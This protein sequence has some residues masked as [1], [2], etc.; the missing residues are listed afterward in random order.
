MNAIFCTIFICSTII[1]CIVNPNAFLSTLLGGVQTAATTALTLFCVYVVWMGISQ[2]CEDSGINRG[3]AKIL[4]PLCRKL[5]K[6]HDIKAINDISM[7]I[8]CNLLGIGGAA[9]PY[10]V[11][12][13]QQLEKEDNTF[14]QNML[15]II[16]AT[17]IQILPTTVITLRAAAASANPNDI[18]LPSLIATSISTLLGICLYI[19]AEKIR[20]HFNRVRSSKKCR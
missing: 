10:A 14:A 3:A 15:F 18:F 11:K 17:S 2:V 20:E 12:A 1:I 19:A 16:N 4:Q 8:S 13:I 5:F 9:T 7:N 6:T